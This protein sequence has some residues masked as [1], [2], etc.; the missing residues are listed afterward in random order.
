MLKYSKN[1]KE[2]SQRLRKQMTDA[3]RLLWF[4]IR[5]KQIKNLQFYRQKPIG[6]YIV[7]FF[8]PRAKLVI[9]I[10]GGQH[11]EIKSEKQD[12]IRDAHLKRLGLKVLRFQNIDVLKNIDSVVRKIW[13]EIPFPPLEKGGK[14]D[15]MIYF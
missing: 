14:G 4:K 10:D 6:N 5:K 7:D 11:Y 8:C 13:D 12:K 2:P 9:E 1:L 3:E 15:L